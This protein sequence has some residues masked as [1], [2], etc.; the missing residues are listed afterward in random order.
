MASSPRNAPGGAADG[1]K[2]LLRRWLLG[3]EA[4]V[5][6]V[7][8]ALWI[9]LVARGELDKFAAPA[10]QDNLLRSFSLQSIFAVGE[11]LVILTGGIDLSVGSLI[12]FDGMLLARLMTEWSEAGMSVAQATYLAM[13]AVLLFSLT[14]G[15]IHASL[16]HFLRLPPF[17]VTLASM[18]IL[19][20]AAQLLNNAVPIPIQ[21]FG[22]ITWLGNKKVFIAGTDWGLPIPAIFMIVLAGITALTLTRTAIGRRVYAVGSNEEAARLS[23]VNV[24]LVRC[25]A[26]GGCSLLTGVAAILYAGYSA[27]GDPLSGTMFELNGISAAVIGG[28]A[29]TGGQGTVAGTVLG[30]I[31]LEWILNIINLTNLTP[32]SP[33]LWRGAIVGVVLLGAVI[34]NHLRIRRFSR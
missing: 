11:L 20:S 16:I 1:A 34:V 9:F 30:A 10:N 28:A 5:L 14:V 2:R 27:Q 6:F 15:L 3:P 26:Y 23:G 31:L 22:L 21:Q 29:L 7:M 12:A 24:F 17:V 33:T 19:R 8:L 32:G 25:F 18:S 13:G 4:S